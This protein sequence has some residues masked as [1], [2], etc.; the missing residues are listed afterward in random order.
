LRSRTTRSFRR[1]FERL[2]SDAQERARTAYQRFEADPDGAGLRFKK[3]GDNPPVYSVRVSE[4]LR[5]LGY[6]DGDTF[7]WFWIGFHA[8]YDRLIRGL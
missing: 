8:E 7:S 3:V 6:R 2:P 4:R 5:A 1:A